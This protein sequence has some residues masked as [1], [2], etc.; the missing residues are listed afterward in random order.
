MRYSIKGKIIDNS[1]KSPILGAQ[2]SYNSNIVN[3]NDLGEFII[4]GD[5]GGERIILSIYKKGYSPTSFP[6]YTGDG[7]LLNNIGVKG[8]IS[9]QSNLKNDKNQFLQ[10][11]NNLVKTISKPEGSAGSQQKSLNKIINNLKLLLIPTVLNL[12][13][14]FGV[15]DI[16]KLLGGQP[17]IP[18]CPPSD[19]LKQ[20]IQ[21]RNK[22]AKQLN[23]LY[24]V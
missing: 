13:S 20:I 7:K 3:T 5:D 8:L 15:T 22:L 4:E 16:P 23:N 18:T 10:L 14:N 2:I 1:S 11:D 17:P 19:K 24:K 9:N 12:I 21:Q 6:P